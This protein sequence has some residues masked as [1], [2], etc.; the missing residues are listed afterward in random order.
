MR[1]A[2]RLRLRERGQLACRR[3]ARRQARRRRRAWASPVMRHFCS[4]RRRC[5][6]YRRR[7]VHAVLIARPLGDRPF[8]RSDLR[9]HDRCAGLR[10][11]G[12]RAGRRLHGKLHPPAAAQALDRRWYAPRPSSQRAAHGVNPRW[13]A[14][15][16]RCA[17]CAVLNAKDSRAYRAAH[18]EPQTEEGFRSRSATA[19]G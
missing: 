6:E 16:H 3:P 14:P 8:A 12:Q 7:G 5:R 13:F 9:L 2:H 10:C 17:R 1:S 19:R 4:A 18:A 11:A 15:A